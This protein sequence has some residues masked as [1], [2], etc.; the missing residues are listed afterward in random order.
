MPGEFGPSNCESGDVRIPV[1]Y[2]VL[3][4]TGWGL[5]LPAGEL[6]Q[7]IGRHAEPDVPYRSLRTG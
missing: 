2:A 3:G 4:L 7:D 5:A 6:L 1:L